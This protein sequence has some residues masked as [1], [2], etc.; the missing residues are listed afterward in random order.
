MPL[1]TS[2]SDA[3]PPRP[4]TSG[5]VA[6][7]VRLATWQITLR[8]ICQC[9][10]HEDPGNA[11]PAACPPLPP[12]RPTTARPPPFRTTLIC[13]YAPAPANV[14]RAIY[15]LPRRAGLVRRGSAPRSR[16]RHCRPRCRLWCCPGRG[17]ADGFAGH[18]GPVVGAPV[19]EGDLNK[20]TNPM[21]PV[22][23]LI[24]IS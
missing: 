4:Q 3:I 22:S 8:V 12:I 7:D 23:G 17:G 24:D 20:A 10:I 13:F 21:P 16:C 9:P 14:T 2:C 1:P 11:T 18:R 6:G 19:L 15:G 5:D